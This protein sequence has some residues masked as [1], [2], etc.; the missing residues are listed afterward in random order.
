[1]DRA[2]RLRETFGSVKYRTNFGG[3]FECF[4]GYGH[5]DSLQLL[6][7]DTHGELEAKKMLPIKK[8]NLFLFPPNSSNLLIA[9]APL[10]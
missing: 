2:A 3:Q 10:C 1:M 6:L 9:V 4:A 5:I 7:H 8:Y